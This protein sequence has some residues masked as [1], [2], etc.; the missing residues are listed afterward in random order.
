MASLLPGVGPSDPVILA[1]VSLVVAVGATAAS[2]IPSRR[3]TRVSPTFA[4][5]SE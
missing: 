4:L 1:I 5:K 3:A 2:F